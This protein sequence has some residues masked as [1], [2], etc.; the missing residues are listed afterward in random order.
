MSGT[1]INQGTGGG[2]VNRKRTMD[3]GQGSSSTR[4]VMMKDSSLC[5]G[6]HNIMGL[7][8]AIPQ[9]VLRAIIFVA[10]VVQVVIGVITMV[11]LNIST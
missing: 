8:R 9:K 11:L 3:Y 4:L 5:D 2:I 7:L 10:G 6:A 1:S